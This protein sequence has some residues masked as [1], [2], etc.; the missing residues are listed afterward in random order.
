MKT[1]LLISILLLFTNA[2]Q[3]PKNPDKVNWGFYG[4]KKINR[5]SIFTLP[6]EMFGFYKEHV[7][8]ITNMR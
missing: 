6:T 4:H 3:V 5:L 7:E 1:L 8:Y 2:E